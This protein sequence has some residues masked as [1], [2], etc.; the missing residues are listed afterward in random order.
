MANARTPTPSR[1]HEIIARARV[2]LIPSR[3]FAT[4]RTS[5]F[6]GRFPENA[7]RRWPKPICMARLEVSA[8]RRLVSRV[9]PDR[10]HPSP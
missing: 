7:L 9:F 10:W 2:G 4:L 5:F 6:A 1:G 8:A 3:A